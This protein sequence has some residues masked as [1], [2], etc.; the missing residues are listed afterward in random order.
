MDVWL[1]DNP[2][3]ASLGELPEVVEINRI[4]RDGPLPQEIEAAEFLV[5][6][7]GSSRVIEALP[8]LS[9]LRVV[10]VNS[11]GV[12]WI[13]SS[14]PEG[15]TLCSARGTR[16]APVA[17]WVVGAI[18]D[19]YKGLARF[20]RQ[21]EQARWRPR[22]PRELAGSKAL[23]VGYGSIGRAVEKRLRPFGVEVMRVASRRRG[24]VY[25]VEAIDELLPQSDIVIVL[26]PAT[27]ET[28]G[29]IDKQ[30]LARLK[31]GALLVNA[32]RGTVVDM[33]ALIDELESSRLQAALDVTDPEPLPPDSPLWKLPN[34]LITPHIAGDSPAADQRVYQLIGDQIRRHLEGRPLLNIVR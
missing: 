34:V 31:T 2:D 21:Q 24:D 22:M 28:V 26:L 9:A 13:A 25:G 1:P 27:P 11:A 14:V 8:R 10:Q 19:S 33:E 23:I 12:D 15:V 3:R 6:P 30:K 32:G 4:P 18:L 7:F 29:L 17:E 5:P 16:D 20:R